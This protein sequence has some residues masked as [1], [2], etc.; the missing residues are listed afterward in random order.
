MGGSRCRKCCND[1]VF[2]INGDMQRNHLFRSRDA[3]DHSPVTYIELFFDL[4]FV[5]A[6]TQLSHR[7]LGHL[8]MIG[9]LETLLLFLAIWWV[10][11]YTS[12]TTNWLDP[13][14]GNVRL[15]LIGLM[16]GGLV[17]S[18]AVPDAFGKT[19]LV[20]AIAYAGMQFFR[21]L[22]MVW[23]SAGVN[24]ARKRNFIRISF[25][26]LLSLPFWLAGAYVSPEQ[27]LICWAVALAI[28]YAG[29][30]A[31]FMTPGLGRSTG[32][33]WDISGGHMAERC[34]LFI[35]IALGEAVLVTG[36]TFADLTHD[37]PTWAAFIIS[38][39]GSATMW[40]IYFDVGAK[41]GSSMIAASANAGLIAR[42]AYTYLHMPIVAGIIVTAVAD[43]LVLGHPFGH[44]SP[45]VIL[46]VI[47]G[48]GLFLIG[49]QAFK[50]VTAEVKYPPLSHFIGLSLLIIVGLLSWFWHWQPLTIAFG[51]TI[52]LIITAIWEWYSLHG[53]WERW[54][55]WM[56]PVF[57]RTPKIRR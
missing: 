21:T 2:G 14:R 20:F 50:W 22:Y 35:I 24:E 23:A 43:E 26:F 57:R 44:S 52:A 4:V 1:P 47:G 37:A 28:E 3:H 27:R 46:T 6:I 29:P 19:G 54:A 9:A 53:G 42:N 36:A 45:I 18:T 13:E 32:V 7:L 25:W 8:T 34:A 55:P 11:I 39:I 15:M 49:N 41:R 17:L 33:D 30:F 16:T 5:F 56:Q 40:W 38:F 51:A 31:F 10:W 12:W 48:P